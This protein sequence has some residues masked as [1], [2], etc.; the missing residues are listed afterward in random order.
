[1]VIDVAHEPLIRATPEKLIT[2]DLKNI[3][4]IG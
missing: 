2:H 3:K 1:M 4:S